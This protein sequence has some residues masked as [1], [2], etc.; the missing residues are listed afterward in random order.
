MTAMRKTQRRV[1]K[2]DTQLIKFPDVGANVP[3]SVAKPE[4]QNHAP[5]NIPI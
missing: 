5:F 2:Y 4:G 1:R 3:D